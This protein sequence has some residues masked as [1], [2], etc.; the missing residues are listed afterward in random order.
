MATLG[1]VVVHKARLAIADLPAVRQLV[2]QV[3]ELLVVCNGGQGGGA[4]DPRMSVVCF[5]ANR[6]TAAAWNEALAWA[7]RRNHEYLY[8]LDQDSVP[9]P[10]AVEVALRDIE[11]EGVAA[12]VQPAAPDRLGLAPF[13]WNAVAS[14]SLHRVSSV[15]GVGG[16]DERLFVDEVDHELFWR[17]I[18]AGYSVRPLPR[19]TIDH[20]VGSP[21]PVR[22]LGLAGWTTGHGPDRRRLQG[23]SAGLLIRR[24]ISSAPATSA[25]LL[26][27]QTVT[28]AKDV[29]AGE[30]GAAAALGAGVAGGMATS[31]P[32]TRAADRSCPY[33]EGPLLGR[34][35]A[36]TDWRYGTGTTAD[37]YRCA[38][39]GALA[40]GRVPE[41]D[42]VASWY[43]DYYTHSIG[44][45]R[46]QVCGRLWPTPAR[47]RELEGL[48]RYLTPPGRSGRF[49]EVGAGLGERLVEFAEAGWDVVGQDPDP[50]AGG[51]A[52]DRGI[53]VHT[54][55]V[56]EL[57]GATEPFDL[58]GM[59]HVLEHV[60]DPGELL[61]A[62]ARLLRPFGRLCIV[63]PNADAFG[64]LLFGR[65]W[66]GLEQPRHLA[67]PTVGSIDRLTSRLGLRTMSARSVSTNAAVILGG[68]LA[69]PLDGRLPR[70][71]LARLAAIGTAGVGQAMG[72]AAVTVNGR[73]GE[74]IVWT[75]GRRR[76]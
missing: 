48:R 2:D 73:L 30:A 7:A 63:A 21:R 61:D 70:G 23:R 58:I 72:R 29:V 34:F 5:E 10:D 71:S 74:E 55:S 17:L 3:E 39:C 14:G 60:P 15:A 31:R 4:P 35:G 9:A 8:L 16:F 43:A 51:L 53:E 36:V 13:P 64:R 47:R 75:G 41:A 44:P 12:L 62:C 19:P 18:Q 49:L 65:W 6:G 50:K 25:R 57:V 54:G 40:A 37:V 20:R 26:L 52:R 22:R 28:A 45:P 67:I 11:A 33:C 1:V 66:F 56:R 42:E 38:R 59:N 27:R 69:R 32:P 76:P 24:Y 68:S 46:A